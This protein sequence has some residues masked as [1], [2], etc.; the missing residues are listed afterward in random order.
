MAKIPVIVTLES[1]ARFQNKEYEKNI[2]K[3]SRNLCFSCF[4]VKPLHLRK[5][6]SELLSFYSLVHLAKIN[7]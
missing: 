3:N 7:T 5:K 2:M 4:L 6:A 1:L